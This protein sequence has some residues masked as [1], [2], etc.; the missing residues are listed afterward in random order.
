MPSS[1]DATETSKEAE[2]LGGLQLASG[3]F[4]IFS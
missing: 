1:T 2:G 4:I 3:I